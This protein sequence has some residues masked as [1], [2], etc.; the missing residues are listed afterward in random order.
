MMSERTKNMDIIHQQFLGRSPPQCASKTML[1]CWARV[2]KFVDPFPN[3]PNFPMKYENI[4][5]SSIHFR[6]SKGQGQ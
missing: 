4:P 6:V 1:A 3:F 5:S 2:F